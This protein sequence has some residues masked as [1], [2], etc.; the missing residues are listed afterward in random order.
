MG[1]LLTPV[2]LENMYDHDIVLCNDISDTINRD[3]YVFIK[4]YKENNPERTFLV[5]REAFNIIRNKEK[6]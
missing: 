2:R 4:V 1:K 3:N 5:N 6:N